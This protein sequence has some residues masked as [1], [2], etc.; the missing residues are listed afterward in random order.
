MAKRYYE[1]KPVTLRNKILDKIRGGHKNEDKEL[2]LKVPKRFEG[3]DDDD[4][5]CDM[6]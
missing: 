1:R 2:D 6:Y 4:G 3:D 5:D